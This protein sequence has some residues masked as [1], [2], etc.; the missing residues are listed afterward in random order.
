[1][2]RGSPHR[3]RMVPIPAEDPGRRAQSLGFG[4][5]LAAVHL[6]T[7]TEAAMHAGTCTSAERLGCHARWTVVAD[8]PVR[9]RV[10]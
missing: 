2:P 9:Y 5:G 10:T 8:M 4:P 6:F 7:V 1:M 3:G